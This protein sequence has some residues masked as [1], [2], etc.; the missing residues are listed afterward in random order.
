VFASAKEK[1]RLNAAK[2][3]GKRFQALVGMGHTPYRRG[4]S[5]TNCA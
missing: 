4:W 5:R 1:K 3:P 2:E